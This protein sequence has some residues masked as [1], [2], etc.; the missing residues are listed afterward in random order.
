MT[1]LPKQL[2]YS[3]SKCQGPRLAM[4]A[5]FFTQILCNWMPNRWTS[6]SLILLVWWQT[7]VLLIAKETLNNRQKNNTKFLVFCCQTNPTPVGGKK[8]PSAGAINN[9]AFEFGKQNA[10]VPRNRIFHPP[11]ATS[12]YDWLCWCYSNLCL[13]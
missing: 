5:L 1:K 12:I 13:K 2:I 4:F 8:Q 9:I 3:R 11:L 7:H 6:L 10:A